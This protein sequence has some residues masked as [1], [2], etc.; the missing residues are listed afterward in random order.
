M[1]VYN[2]APHLA[3]AIES[4]LAQSFGDFEF[5]IV[6]DGSTDGSGAMIDAYAAKDARIR[7]IH[8]DN[9][10]LIASLNRILHE[11]R[12]P[13]VAR[14]DGDD[15]ALPA[16]FERQIAFLADH[17]DH[18]VVGTWVDCIDEDGSPRPYR[19]PV[20]PTSHDELLKQLETGPSLCHPSVMMRRDVVLAAGGYHR[21][22]VHCEDYD[23]WL[24][25]SERT[26]LTSIPERL[27]LY[28]HSYSQVSSRHILSQTTGA[29]IAW[30]AHVERASG[31]PDPMA[32]LAALPPIDKLDELFGRS[33]IGRAVRARV[34]GSILYSPVASKDEGYRLLLD[35][36]RSGGGK[37]GLWR[38][39]ARLLKFGKP[40]RA[41]RL[42][43][44]LATH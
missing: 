44:A 21:A 34:V 35:H 3:Q 17:P 39:A 15:I 12:A 5:L 19:C 29:A 28:R 27:L 25:L 24:R 38:A 41:L 9:R 43:A 42:A 40:A 6:N 22:Y 10:G 37:N 8:Q 36:V 32:E 26:R 13:L 33:G 11:A 30:A 16:R 2:N 23:L 7:A 18:G 20:Q 4:I 1:S 31:R 14:M